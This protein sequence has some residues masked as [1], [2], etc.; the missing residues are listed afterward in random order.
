MAVKVLSAAKS[1]G[2][3][4]FLLDYAARAAARGLSVGGVASPAVFEG[5][6]RIGYDLIDL[7]TG[8]RRTLARVVDEPGAAT[9]VGV[10]Q[11][12]ST[13]VEEGNAAIITAVRGGLDLVAIDEVGPLEFRGGGW[14]R[15]L[16]VCLRECTA[17]QE[18]VIVVRPSLVDELPARFP[19]PLWAAAERV[20]PPWPASPDGAMGNE[21]GRRRNAE[22]EMQ[23]G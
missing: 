15:A 23:S 3:T 14:G 6:Q 4:S 7:R 18:L 2:K 5:G 16:Q 19:S 8:N 9:A 1:E 13:A 12:D 10:Y 22:R 21:E 20:S 11:F 17:Q